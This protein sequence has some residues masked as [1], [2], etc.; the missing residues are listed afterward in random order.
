MTLLN[1]FSL[2]LGVAPDSQQTM[3]DCF[4]KGEK[5]AADIQ[6][7]TFTYVDEGTK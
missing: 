2:G 6:E 3:N 7:A 4:Q 5:F 1:K